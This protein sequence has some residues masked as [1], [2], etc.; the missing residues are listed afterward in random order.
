MKSGVYKIVNLIDN[1]MY[2]GSSN[3][4]TQRLSTH[5][6]ALVLGKHK[7]PK[8]QR[9]WN[10]YG[11]QQFKF[12]D[13]FECADCLLLTM[14]QLYIDAMWGESCYNLNKVAG[15][16]PS[17]KGKKFSE[18]HKQRIRESRKGISTGPCSE[19][20]KQ[21]LSKLYKGR[22]IFSAETKR[23]ISESKKGKKHS[24]ETRRKISE[25]KKRSTKRCSF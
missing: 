1:K 21:K 9:A 20:R 23:K 3:N 25:T 8:L 13:I 7:N 2:I 17:N 5:K 19:E 18:E 16:P 10:K 15:K 12:E 24:D 14:E 6:K 11:A 4:I 22:K